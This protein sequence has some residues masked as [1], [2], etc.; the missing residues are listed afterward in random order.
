MPYLSA[1]VAP[2]LLSICDGGNVGF[3]QGQ[4]E[5][6]RDRQRQTETDSDRQRQTETDSDKQRQTE[7]DRPANIDMHRQR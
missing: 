1:M 3:I 4:T 5:T 2:C 6:D 7:T